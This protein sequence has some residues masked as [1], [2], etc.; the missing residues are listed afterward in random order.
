M[1]KFYFLFFFTLSFLARAQN[2]S[3]VAQK[4]GEFPGFND[5]V[6]SIAAQTDGKI[7]LGGRFTA[8]NGASANFIIRLN[9]DGSRDTSFSTGTG[10][11]NYVKTIVV[12]ADGK[13]L[14]GTDFTTYNGVN[15]NRIIRLNT[16]GSKDIS[17]STGSGFNNTVFAIAV[18]ADGKILVGGQFS[19]YN[20]VTANSII[21]LNTNGSK[22]TSFITGIGFSSFVTA[23]ATQ[24]D[25]KILVGGEFTSY[26]GATAMRIVRLNTNGNKDTSFITGIGF[27]A[28]VSTIATQA[29]GKILVGG[30]FTNYN[31]VTENRIIR[32]NTD[33][34]KDTSFSIGTRFNDTVLVIT[35]QADGKILVGGNFT[36]YNGVAENFIIRLNTNGS[37]DTSF[38]T[39]TGFN[40]FVFAIAVQTDGK[41]LVGGQFGTYDGVLTNVI[42]RLNTDGSK[43][44]SFLIGTGFNS[45]V[46]ATAV[47][48]DGNI[49]VGGFFTIYNGVIENRIIRLNAN[50]SKDIS[51]STGTGFNNFV[52][53]I[54]VQAD[55]KILVGGYFTSYNGATENR[56]IRLNINGSKDTS[57]STGTGF[58]NMVFAIAEQADGKILVGG[59]FSTYDGV[60]ANRI[61]RLNA[62]GSKDNS[63]SIGT[64]FDS[65]VLVIAAQADGK[66]LLVGSFVNYNGVTANRI[67]RLNADGSKDNSFS[68][69]TGFND[70][71]LAIATQADG[72]ILVG[73]QF[74]TY[75]GATENRI[76]RLNANGS[77]DTSFTTGTGFN[78][79]VY[80]IATQADG[81][82]LVGGLFTTYNGVVENHII[83]LNA[84]G[85]KDT[86][87]S[88][89]TGFNS[90]VNEIA[91]QAD[92]K[93]LVGGGFNSYKGDNS[94]VFLISLYSSAVLSTA[95]FTN[96]DT[97]ALW[98]NPAKEILTINS[99]SNDVIS[100]VKIYD[101]QGKL[102]MESSD[103][104]T[105]VSTLSSG[106]YIIKVRTEAGEFTEKF[107]RE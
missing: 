46:L 65:T 103:R 97:I 56:M 72:K 39:G 67:I 47:Q 22:D 17:F 18:Q 73:G 13:I 31:G 87:F 106:L 105:N 49:L 33:A 95:E 35:V 24:S 77:K 64:G 34:T 52:E 100:M 74:N 23:I 3:D 98:P 69:G 30:Y 70:S 8:Y 20:G 36:S 15:E 57:F 84:D 85:I 6:L 102:V 7:L 92:G 83:R 71:V 90:Q 19:T 50:G 25:G 4:F 2:P 82:I 28:S 32:L 21:R 93:I 37:K 78:N 88:T 51:F 86:S 59:Q 41:I 26:N 76:I 29:D 75:D 11:D 48:A 14:V 104:R 45:T 96:A 54:V 99:L 79:F 107:I 55:G 58:D 80:A 94:S 12:Q 27:N 40:S 42:I 16:D 43:G 62:D 5:A 68:V 60:T 101:L 61:I 66:I 10:F 89:G 53:K 9:A 38:G 1:K 81:K 63:F 91:L 44:A